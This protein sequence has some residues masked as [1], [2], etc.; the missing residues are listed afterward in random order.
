MNKK[1]L[2]PIQGKPYSE[3][4]VSSECEILKSKGY[5]VDYFNIN[6]LKYDYIK[7]FI[8]ALI[9]PELLF[10]CFWVLVFSLSSKRAIISNLDCMLRF[11]S[12]YSEIKFKVRDY[13]E[14]RCH[15]LA[16]RAMF[17]Y[18]TYISFN[19]DYTLVA[20]AVDI[21]DWDCSTFYKVKY[22]KRIDCISNYNKGFL[23][24]K[25]KFSYSNK[26][27]LIRN[28][29][30]I[31][32]HPYKNNDN[33]TSISYGELRLLYV[34]RFVKKKNLVELLHLLD[35]IARA[36]D[37]PIIDLIMIG[38]GGDDEANVIHAA[39]D[40]KNIRV[41]FLGVCDNKRISEEIK[42]ANFTILLSSQASKK[43]PD[44]DG[45]PTIFL[46]S[47]SQGTPIITTEV[48][49]IPE[50]VIDHVNGIVLNG[51]DSNEL[52]YK[53]KCYKFN[54]DEIIKQF[55][56]WYDLGNATKFY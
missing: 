35:E 29:F 34:G 3:T 7:I 50:L 56:N 43:S 10:R 2:Y 41:S 5:E 26:F 4:F 54:S 9:H 51:L 6:N 16:K 36:D 28:S 27:K 53:L 39:S 14:V 38:Q 48:S 22:A 21:F 44:Q 13:G 1:I 49:G 46:E 18:L 47:L 8:N 40:A 17:G 11:F 30:Y 24:A 23:D 33:D 32:S 55:K 25:L 12:N 42:L 37:A 20:H 15:F 45:I 19:I 31:N 52:L